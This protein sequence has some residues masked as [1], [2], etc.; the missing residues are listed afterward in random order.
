MDKTN[1]QLVKLIEA[2]KKQASVE[3][4]DLWSRIAT[5]LEKSTRKRPIVNLY[6]INKCTKQEETIIIPGKVLS[7][8]ELD[9]RVN[10]AAFNFSGNAAA[11]IIKARGKILSIY[12]LL[13]TNPKAKDVRIIV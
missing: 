13:K 8:G 7:M 4:V 1:I 11:K 3:G 9:H 10:I 6:K 2:L 5:D 12:E